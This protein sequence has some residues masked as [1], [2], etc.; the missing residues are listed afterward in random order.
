MYVLLPPFGVV[1]RGKWHAYNCMHWLFCTRGT[2]RCDVTPVLALTR[3][4]WTNVTCVTLFTRFGSTLKGKGN[5]KIASIGH[6]VLGNPR[7]R[8]DTA[9]NI[10]FFT[11]IH[12]NVITPFYYP[13]WVA[14][15]GK[16]KLNILALVSPY[17]EKPKVRHVSDFN[18]GSF[19]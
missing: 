15:G 14:V 9:F 19:T 16:T 5:P 10:D 8:Y 13:C 3:F 12:G 1:L 2:L 11:L 18:L 6:C 4:T 7:V 17:S